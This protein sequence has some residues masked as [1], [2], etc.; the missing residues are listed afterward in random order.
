MLAASSAG[1]TPVPGTFTVLV[2]TRSAAS[3]SKDPAS[4]SPTPPVSVATLYLKE[5]NGTVVSCT[6]PKF[7]VVKYTTYELVNYSCNTPTRIAASYMLSIVGNPAREHV[8]AGTF[9]SECFTTYTSTTLSEPPYTYTSQQWTCS[10]PQHPTPPAP[11][12]K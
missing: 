7:G 6:S 2:T 9:D 12:N 8:T 1:A 10:A 11:P 5:G 3:V 4:K